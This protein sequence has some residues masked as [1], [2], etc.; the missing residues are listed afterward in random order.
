MILHWT[1]KRTHQ[2]S[3][4]NYVEDCCFIVFPEVTMKVERPFWNKLG[5]KNDCFLKTVTFSN[6]R[7]CQKKTKKTRSW[8]KTFLFFFRCPFCLSLRVPSAIAENIKTLN[9]MHS[10]HSLQ[11]RFW[12]LLS[13]KGR[14]WLIFCS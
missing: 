10:K 8:S 1:R 12:I 2:A 13:F 14:F 4:C 9:K 7:L 5:I 11:W 6:A 3:L